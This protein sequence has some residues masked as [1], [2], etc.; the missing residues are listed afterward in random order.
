MNIC[1]FDLETTSLDVKNANILEAAL[2]D[3]NTGDTILHS[4]V[5]PYDDI[6]IDNTNIHGIDME[7]LSK[8]NA[9]TLPIFTENFKSII[10]N[11][12]GYNSIVYIIAHN[13]FNYDQ[14]VLE[15][16]FKKINVQFDLNIIFVDSLLLIRHL[17]PGLYQYNLKA[18]AKRIISNTQDIV[19]HTAIDDS[20]VLAQIIRNIFNANIN[21]FNNFDAFI[22]SFS[23]PLLTSEH[24][25]NC[26]LDKIP[27]L[28]NLNDITTIRQ[29]ID[30]IEQFDN[31]QLK[32]YLK[33]TFNLKR[34]STIDK[35]INHLELI[36]KLN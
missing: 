16:N 18:L 17:I 13:N 14:L 24:I 2:I 26:S 6:T 29:L 28:S 7:S 15:Y 32:L 3:Y 8:N 10:N 36:K 27:G 4:Y 31:E 11:Y 5:Y 22:R 9:I 20:K 35:I 1:I 25:F 33:D 34:V 21:L 30:H 19:F 12:Y 23:R